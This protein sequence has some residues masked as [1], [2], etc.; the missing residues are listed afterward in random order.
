MKA[1][2]TILVAL[3]VTMES[4]AAYPIDPRPLRKLI[5]ESELIII[6]HVIEIM[7]MEKQERTIDDNTIARIRIQEVLKGIIREQVID[8]PYNPNYICPAPPHYFPNT[9]VVVFLK[10]HKGTFYTH[11]LSYGVK[12]LTPEGITV[13]RA[14]IVEMLDILT[15]EDSYAQFFETVEWLV[16]CVEHPETRWEGTYELS[17]ESD[18]MSFYAQSELKPFQSMLSAEQR[19]RLATALF[20]TESPGYADLGLIDLV[21]RENETKV[22]ALLVK[23]LKELPENS[24]F[25]ANEYMERIIRRDHTPRLERL[26][27]EFSSKQF[28]VEDQTKLKKIVEE[29]VA[30]AEER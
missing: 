28:S 13:Y 22:H 30:V 11:A 27:K 3:A 1:I 16:K 9:D 8:V 15:M 7:K 12:T 6:G 14:R 18:F 21:Y 19:D 2:L 17:P 24:L 20:A 10:E 25:F 29:F 5:A 23:T 26:A 4:A